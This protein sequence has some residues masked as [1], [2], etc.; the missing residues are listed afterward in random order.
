MTMAT[1]PPPLALIQ[2]MT[3]YWV[4]QSISVAAQLGLADQ[5]RDGPQTSEQLAEACDAHAP[6]V[7]RLLRGDAD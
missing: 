4:S 1:V 7:Y 3:T 5:L 6:S 2:I